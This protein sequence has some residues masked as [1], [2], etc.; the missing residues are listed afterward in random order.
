MNDRTLKIIDEEEEMFAN[1]QIRSLDPLLKLEK[2]MVKE[3][4]DFS[5]KFDICIQVRHCIHFPCSALLSLTLQNKWPTEGR[6]RLF[7]AQRKE[8][9]PPWKPT[10]SIHPMLSN[11]SSFQY[12]KAT[13]PTM[14][15]CES[16]RM[17]SESYA[18]TCSS[19]RLASSRE[20]KRVVAIQYSMTVE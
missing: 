6:F 20:L 16:L 8:A 9:V 14:S 1:S 10:V 18:P 7:M 2:E 19:V 3:G 17:P 12:A 5:E 13:P 11:N 4:M 15:G